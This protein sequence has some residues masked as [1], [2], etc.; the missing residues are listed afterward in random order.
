MRTKTISDILFYHRHRLNDAGLANQVAQADG[1]YGVL[2]RRAQK[3]RLGKWQHLPR[4]SAT[5]N[6]L[7]VAAA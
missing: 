7:H 2:F 3:R 6:Q 1:K 5:M 4:V